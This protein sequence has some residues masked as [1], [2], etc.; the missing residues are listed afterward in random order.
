MEVREVLADFLK[1]GHT[2][3]QMFNLVKYATSKKQSVVKYDPIYISIFPTLRCN[4]NCDMCITH[5]RKFINPYGQ[6]PSRDLDFDLF[7]QVLKRYRNAL[8]VNLIGNGEPLFH[9]DIFRMIEYAAREMKMYTYSGSNGIILGEF[10]EKIVASPLTGFTVSVNGHNAAEFHRMTGMPMSCFE[11]IRDNVVA[12]VKRRNA[13]RSGLQISASIILDRE[14]Y[15]DLPDMVAFLDG[16]GVDRALFFQ[17]LASPAPGFTVGERALFSDDP[18]VVR[19]FD[20]VKALQKNTRVKF[21]LPPLLERT[22]DGK[23][24][25][26]P[27]YNIT[28]D[29]EGRVGGCS[30]QVLDLTGHGRFDEGDAW[31]SDLLKEFRRRFIDPEFPLLEPCQWCYNNQGRSRLVSNP[32]PVSFLV[33]RLFSREK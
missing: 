12:L 8:A 10:V 31:N 7:K 20:R 22:M 32:N 24:C 14:N 33:R 27:F 15:R 5:T 13:K 1:G 30:C 4:L 16:L 2:F 26:V 9:K 25:S 18:D 19:T 21:S 6:Q 28:V 11:V 17:F 23:Y 3:G 29:G